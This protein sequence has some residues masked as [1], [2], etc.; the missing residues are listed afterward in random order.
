MDHDWYYVS[1]ITRTQ[2]GPCSVNELGECFA[3]S[4]VTGST[5][6]WREGMGAW[7]PLSTVS[8][9]YVEVS[10]ASI[11]VLHRPTT[12]AGREECGAGRGAHAASTGIGTMLGE[13][14][15]RSSLGI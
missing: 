3:A 13:V 12:V 2:Q 11:V 14:Q 1:D 7:S 5:L 10:R 8:S 6:V 9:L 4:S 15:S